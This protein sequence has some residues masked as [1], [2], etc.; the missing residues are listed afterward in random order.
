MQMLQPPDSSAHNSLTIWRRGRW[1]GKIDI[2]S[3]FADYTGASN[4]CNWWGDPMVKI[5][6]SQTRQSSLKD[7]NN[8]DVH[9]ISFHGC[10]DLAKL[11][12]HGYN[13]LCWECPWHVRVANDIQCKANTAYLQFKYC[14]D[15]SRVVVVEDWDIN[16]RIN[17]QALSSVDSASTGL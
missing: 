5:F 10:N 15:L 12:L 16:N 6:S 3:I 2:L 11:A 14:T 17:S 8:K 4:V 7:L 13:I 1:P 9:L